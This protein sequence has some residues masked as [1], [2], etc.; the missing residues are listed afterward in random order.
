[1]QSEYE[2]FIF[3][4]YII[5]VFFKR[6]L[7]LYI[8]IKYPSETE[9]QSGFGFDLIEFKKG[10]IYFSLVWLLYMLLFFK[11]N[12]NMVLL[13]YLILASI[14]YYLLFED[15]FIYYFI[16]KSKTNQKLM[17]YL[18]EQGAIIFNSI[19]FIIYFY[20]VNKLIPPNFYKAYI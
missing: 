1:M 12:H 17:R 20:L 10:L 6:M 9:V 18:D 13:L 15:D 4:T 8:S 19:F 2:I 16:D 11:L 3:I 5:F 7:D 14:L